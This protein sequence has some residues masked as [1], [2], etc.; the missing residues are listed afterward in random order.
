MESDIIPWLLLEHIK[1]LNLISLFHEKIKLNSTNWGKYEEEEE[2]EEE[3]GKGRSHYT[4]AHYF[5]FVPK[6]QSHRLN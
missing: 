3:E 5:G 4:Q 1:F 2:E 6:L